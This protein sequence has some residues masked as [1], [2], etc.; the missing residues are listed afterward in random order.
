MAKMNKSRNLKHGGKIFVKYLQV[1][2]ERDLA[3]DGCSL[4]IYSMILY[5]K[6]SIDDIFIFLDLSFLFY[7]N[8]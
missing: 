6:M 3:G 4:L 5:L 2:I 1:I 8:L 7:I